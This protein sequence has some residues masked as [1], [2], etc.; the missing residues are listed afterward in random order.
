MATELKMPKMGIDMVDGTI[1]RWLKSEGDAVKAEE[2]IAEIETDKSTV[3][4]VAPEDGVL[5]KVVAAEDELVPVGAVLAYIG[6]AG[7]SVGGT[8]AAPSAAVADVTPVE[9]VPA[10]V[11]AVTSNEIKATP[12]AQRFAKEEGINL[13]NVSGTG[14]G[15]KITKEDVEKV[16]VELA[17]A[18]P[19]PPGGVKASPAARRIARKKGYN[20]ANVT[21]TGPDGRIVVRDVMAYQPKATPAPV[22]AA[23]QP[24]PV[25]VPTAPVAPVAPVAPAVPA[26]P[27]P[28][29]VGIGASEEVP[30]SRMRKR[31]TQVL[32]ASKAPVPHFYVTMDIDMD[33]AIALRKQMN[34]TLADEG[35][36]ISFNDLIVKATALT[37]KKFPNINT[38]FAGD[39][40]IRHGDI[41]VGVAVSTDNGLITIATR[42]T[43]KLS[44]T[45]L[46]QVTR[47]R[48]GR[49]RAGKIKPDDIG[50]TT[51]T[52]SNLGM[53]GV[54]S[55]VAIITP[56]EAGILAVGGIQQVPVVKA[57]PDGGR[58]SQIV[59]GNRMKV[60]I[61][62]DHRVTDG[63]E[64]AQFMVELKRLLENPMRLML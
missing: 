30:L 13:A 24:T 48:A 23:P 9:T 57:C 33:A 45:E 64:G 28:R 21:G 54:E 41:N 32:T 2:A 47:T 18:E 8:D 60:T 53:Y 44:L 10:P 42:N 63:A 5:I 35:L 26:A 55:F 6:Q 7:E 1:A 51:F 20:M 49:A 11:E 39:K 27:A 50:G 4:L 3:E 29:V 25:A 22:V 12:V 17:N 62:A 52:V 36:K 34:A 15:G 37:L 16:M 31:I 38:S 43:D 56:P 46:S 19:A 61:S 14:A 58:N 59:I 40:I